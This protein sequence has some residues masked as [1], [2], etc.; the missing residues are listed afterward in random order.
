MKSKYAVLIIIIALLISAWAPLPAN[1]NAP[2]QDAAAA[3][4]T[5]TVNVNNKTGETLK[6]SMSGPTNYS[7]TIK[8]GKS[9]INVAPGKYKYIYQA[10]GGQKKGTV[11]VKK[12]NTNLVLAACNK[13]QKNSG[14]TVNIAVQN[15]TGGY[16]TMNL[17]G[18]S[19]YH[20]S[21]GTGRSTISVIKG[22]YQYV[23]YGCGGASLSGTRKLTGKTVWTF[24]C[25]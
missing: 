14:G 5:L 2:H 9:A 20:F 10:C 15:N 21:L 23:V 3:S 16:I 24:F 6:L 25:Y 4:S 11:D 13:N 19:Y 17:T 22:S 1:S 18:P 8:P 7:F 12:N